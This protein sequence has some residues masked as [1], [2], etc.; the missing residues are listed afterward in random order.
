MDAD[1]PPT[2]DDSYELDAIVENMASLHIHLNDELDFEVISDRIDNI[3]DY[4]NNVQLTIIDNVNYLVHN[5]GSIYDS[6]SH[7][8]IGQLVDGKII[9]KL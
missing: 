7:T 2:N 3:D 6:V 8:Y 9:H 4:N 5:N 1:A